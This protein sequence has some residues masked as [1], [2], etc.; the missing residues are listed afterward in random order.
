M[1]ICPPTPFCLG[2]LKDTHP[3]LLSSSNPIHLGQDFSR[4]YHS[5]MSFS[6]KR[7]IILELESNHQSNQLGELND[8]L[9]FIIPSLSL[10]DGTRAYSGTM[11]TC[12]YWVSYQPFYGQNFQLL[13]TKFTALLQSRGKKALQG[14]RPIIEIIRFKV[15]LSS[16]LLLVI[17]PFYQ[18]ENQ[19]AE[20]GHFPRTSNNK[21]YYPSTP[22]CQ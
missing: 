6:Q 12:F 7:E 9:M 22:C 15:S 10:S 21:H 3:F 14:I 5:E 8:T 1:G 16:V 2:P 19:R 17:F 18:W 11:I 13:L 20:G 4:K